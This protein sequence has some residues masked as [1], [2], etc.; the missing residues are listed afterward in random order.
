MA[1]KF[2]LPIIRRAQHGDA[3]CQYRLGCIYLEGGEGLA[4]NARTAYMWLNRAAAQ[5]MEQAWRTI[6]ERISPIDSDGDG[7][8]ARWYRLAATSGSLRAKRMLAQLLVDP[9]FGASDPSGRNCAKALL[10]Q[11]AVAGDAKACRDL[12]RLLIES[13][14]NCMD[15]KHALRLLTRAY[16]HGLHEVARD[17]ADLHWRRREHALAHTWYERCPPP[18]DAEMCYRLGTLKTW[19]GQTGNHLLERAA[20]EG[21]A[22]ACEQLGLRLATGST[23]HRRDLKK[24]ARW[25]ELAAAQGSPRAAYLLATIYR[26]RASSAYDDRRARRWLFRAA[27]YGHGEACLRAGKELLRS[28]DSGY[29]T[30]DEIDRSPPD[31]AAA[32]FLIAAAK[33]GLAAAPRELARLIRPIAPGFLA[34]GNAW[35]IL[36]GLAE[37]KDPA[38]GARVKLGYALG[39][40]AR[41]LLAIEPE[42]C[43]LGE[44]FIVS[45]AGRRPLR[46]RIVL[47][48]SERQ[49]RLIDEAKASLRRLPEPAHD[50]A[51]AND[52]RSDYLK[53]RLLCRQFGHAQID[54]AL[55]PRGRKSGLHNDTDTVPQ[56]RSSLPACPRAV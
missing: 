2:V 10:E 21:H 27:R 32:E 56:A 9:A 42:H 30:P 38:I 50:G 24:A 52:F 53:L 26:H 54:I 43:D 1:S 20:R 15:D 22:A 5:G 31:A 25:L 36:I 13:P 29:T 48:D 4:A 14:D 40:S 34:H 17:L 39:L 6:G 51:E 19:L 11:A 37:R 45:I 49:R 23:E 55:F 28:I 3:E 18:W 46:R 33:H 12:G 44:C 16:D 35:S 47:V 8:L 41:E 7:E